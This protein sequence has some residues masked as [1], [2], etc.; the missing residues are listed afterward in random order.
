MR[1]VLAHDTDDPA[2]ALAARWG[3]RALLVTPGAVRRHRWR[4]SIGESGAATASVDD[5]PV[6]AVVTRLGGV[7]PAEL[8]HVA[9]DDR[10]Y[11]AA[12]LTAFLT[13]WLTACACPVVN[14]PVAGSLNGPPLTAYGWLEL[15]A[16]VGLAT[17]PVW[18]RVE[19]AA[20]PTYSADEPTAA[21]SA[22]VVVADRCLGEVDAGTA[23]RL[24]A[25]AGLAGCALVGAVVERAAGR[26][27]VSALTPWPDVGDPDVADA[28]DETLPAP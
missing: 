1:L 15:A 26:T 7:A 24:V 28:L 8:P 18:E 23:A 5:A 12:E 25:L 6:S 11:A 10:D 16:R 21:G 17:R 14:R 2:R 13:G 27:V 3:G 9:P 19:P 4:L 20:P 22:A